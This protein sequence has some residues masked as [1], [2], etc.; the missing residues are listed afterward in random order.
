MLSFSNIF[1]AHDIQC[2]TCIIFI[3]RELVD[4]LYRDETDVPIT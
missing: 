4:S 3:I 2:T 1:Y